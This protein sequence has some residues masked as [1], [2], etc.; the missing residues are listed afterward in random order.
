MRCVT[1]SIM[2][3]QLEDIWKMRGLIISS[4]LW[5]ICLRHNHW[6]DLNWLDHSKLGNSIYKLECAQFHNLLWTFSYPW[7]LLSFGWID[8]F[9]YPI[10]TLGEN[11]VILVL[12]LYL[13]PV[14]KEVFAC[15]MMLSNDE[16]EL[17]QKNR[18]PGFQPS[19]R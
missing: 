2:L 15:F 1:K 17:L 9:F 12:I 18:V 3:L 19:G 13:S 4:F 11:T 8:W 10:T 14:E 7:N 6:V 5:S 16:L